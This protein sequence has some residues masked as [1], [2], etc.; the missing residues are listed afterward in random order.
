MPGKILQLSGNFFSSEFEP[1]PDKLIMINSFAVTRCLQ[2]LKSVLQR[3]LAMQLLVKWYG[4]RN[5]PGPQNF[6]PKQEWHLF[7]V[8]LCS[9]LGYDVDKLPLIKEYEANFL[10]ELNSSGV[11]SK[12]QKTNNSGSV[13]D[14]AYT[15]AYK[16]TQSFAT[17][18]LGLTK[19]TKS[20]KENSSLDYT[21]NTG[22]I[23]NQE[24]LF[25]YIP[26]VLFSLHLLY[27]ELKLNCLMTESL[28]WLAQ[29]LHKLSV[30]LRFD[31]Y[32]HHYFLDYPKQC[33]RNA[34]SQV[35]EVD[36]QK[37]TPPNYM[38][39]KPASVFETLNNLMNLE[40]VSSFPFLN[41]VNIKTKNIVQLFA[42]I[43]NEGRVQNL[44]M[45]KFV[46][47]IVPAGSRVDLQDP[48]A[49][50]KD[51]PRKVEQPLAE[52]IVFLYHEMGEIVN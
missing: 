30:D 15:S 35:S 25:P 1:T 52:R 32:S 23:R 41:Q 9:L 33:Q 2:T 46:K 36:L 19:L 24:T 27:E 44:D 16:D 10:A 6:S 45:E 38:S 51:V 20:K 50:I 40:E 37:I 48:G 17:N 13:E 42:L 29:L 49:F 26:L 12:K 21:T 7:L 11:V 39:P 4:A 14:W 47:L 18:V 31:L 3:D 34:I 43:A 22:S 8:T 5:A 28:P